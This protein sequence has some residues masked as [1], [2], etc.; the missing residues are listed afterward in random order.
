MAVDKHPS[1]MPSKPFKPPSD[2]YG[3]GERKSGQAGVAYGVKHPF[4]GYEH[5]EHSHNEYGFQHK[6][7]VHGAGDHKSERAH[8]FAGGFHKAGDQKSNDEPG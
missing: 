5:D 6:L 2:R 7:E 3:Q 4:E 8:D 1:R